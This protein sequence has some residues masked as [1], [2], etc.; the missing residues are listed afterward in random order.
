MGKPKGHHLKDKKQA[1]FVAQVD[2]KVLNR[3]NIDIMHLDGLNHTFG[4]AKNQFTWDGKPVVLQAGEVHYFRIPS[5]YWKDRILRIKAMGMNAIQTYVPWNFH[6]PDEGKWDFH[7]EMHDV[8]K[9]LEIA[10]ELDMPVVF[11]PGPYICAEWTGGGLPGWL[12]SK[13]GLQLRTYEKQYIGKVDLFWNK[14]LPMV[15]PYLAEHGGP[16]IMVQLENEFG[17]IGDTINKPNDKRYIEHLR[18]LAVQHLGSR[19]LLFTDDPAFGGYPANEAMFKRGGI[20]GIFRAIN[21]GPET[22]NDDV[23][24]NAHSYLARHTN[25]NGKAPL[26]IAETYSGWFTKWDEKRITRKK[27]K[28]VAKAMLKLKNAGTSLGLYMAHG[29]TNFGFWAGANDG[30]FIT[31]YDYNAPIREG[32]DHGFGI[33]GKDKYWQLQQIFGAG[34]KLVEE[35]APPAFQKLPSITMEYASPLREEMD[36]MCHN[37]RQMIKGGP[38]S[39]EKFGHSMGLMAYRYESNTTE[40]AGHNIEGEASDNLHMWV[41][42]K[43]VEHIKGDTHAVKLKAQLPKEDWGIQLRR[44]AGPNTL[45]IVVD[46]HGPNF[47]MERKQMH[48]TRGL[49]TAKLDQ[50]PL[51][52]GAEGQ[53]SVC[54]LRFEEPAKLSKIAKLRATKDGAA[55]PSFWATSMNVTDTS[56]DTYMHMAEGWEKGVAFINGFNL[57]RYDVNSPQKDL[58]VPASVLK[59]GTNEV[60]ILE[61][62][63]KNI[64]KMGSINFIEQRITKT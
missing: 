2:Q 59:Q 19:A 48:D 3:A 64:D 28:D 39:A 9:F 29:G 34:R 17:V 47:G 33:D 42:R 25:T 43:F 45:D 13:P 38:Q 15:K 53:W 52:T 58:Y 41:N 24:F 5:M 50:K 27:T 46:T 12:Q 37:G 35:P 60:V 40:L 32:G 6:E 11:R 44:V 57:G 1:E 22:I 51:N 61:T 30:S 8:T 31:S 23:A 36:D 49:W 20:P 14:L 54:A 26:Y 10:K 4:I 63:A 16:I 21:M 62:D 55:G 56:K 18:D 7:S